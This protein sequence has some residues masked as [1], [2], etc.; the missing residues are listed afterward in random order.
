MNEE[1]AFRAITAGVLLTGIFVGGYFRRKA[2]RKGG[3]MRS[4]EGR[5]LVR[6]LRLLGLIVLLPVLGYIINPEWVAWA[7]F[8]LPA[9]VRWVAALVTLGTIPLFIWVL[10]SIGTNITPTQAT[11]QSHTLVTHG[12]YRWVRHPFYSTGLVFVIA[13]TLMTTLWWLGLGMIPMFILLLRTPKEEANL[14]AAF[15]D[16]YREYMKRTGRFFPRF[17]S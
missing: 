16:E 3:P 4:P 17:W 11:C 2:E 7:R 10:V 8:S 12:P 9:G 6:A 1:F 14:I 5:G 13:V 15:G